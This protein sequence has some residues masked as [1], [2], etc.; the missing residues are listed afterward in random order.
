M[1]KTDVA[2]SL[3]LLRDLD[4]RSGVP[5]DT[6]RA[7]NAASWL[8]R[9]ARLR[10]TESDARSP[11]RAGKLHLDVRAIINSQR[12]YRDCDF[13]FLPDRKRSSSCLC[14]ARMNTWLLF[15]PGCLATSIE[16]L[17]LLHP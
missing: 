13:S 14:S 17:H 7:R 16:R 1:A 12:R 4:A 10:G 5:P 3:R 2:V 9:K 15:L 8:R 11:G 6:R